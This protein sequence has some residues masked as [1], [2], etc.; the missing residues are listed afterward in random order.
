MS[1]A[2]YWRQECHLARAEVK[3]LQARV[4]R[5]ELVLRGIADSKLSSGPPIQSRERVME[6][7]VLADALCEAGI[8]DWFETV[9]GHDGSLVILPYVELMPTEDAITD[10]RVAGKCLESIREKNQTFGF[11]C[12]GRD[13]V[14]AEICEYNV[15]A[16]EHDILGSAISES[17]PRAIIEAWYEAT[18]QGEDND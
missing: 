2:L 12:V 16:R 13:Q 8:F 17:L 14:E 11:A 10:W 7:K 3:R 6:P 1:N 9:D 4:A 18:E 5:L 15:E